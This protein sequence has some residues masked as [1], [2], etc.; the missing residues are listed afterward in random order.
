[1]V[2]IELVTC[3]FEIKTE[4][5]KS[6][7]IKKFSRITLSAVGGSASAL[8]LLSLNLTCSNLVAPEDIQPGR[9]DYVWTVDTLD[10]GMNLMALRTI[11]GANPDDV[12]VA[13]YASP[14]RY[15]LW[16]WDGLKWRPD[17]I[18]SL[19]INGTP[20]GL[21]GFSKD[22]IWLNSTDGGYYHFDGI[23]W[24][25]RSVHRFQDYEFLGLNYLFG[26]S[27]NNIYSVGMAQKN[28]QGD[29]HVGIIMRFDGKEWRFIDIPKMKIIFP[30]IGYQYSSK[31][32]FVQGYKYYTSDNPEL[33][34]LFNGKDLIELHRGDGI[35]TTGNIKGEIYA[36][37]G[38]KIFKYRN[39][40]ILFKDFTDQ[41]YKGRIWGRSEKDFFTV[42]ADGIGHY[43]G[44][45]LIT[46]FKTTNMWPQNAVIYD[47]EVFFLCVDF[48][49]WTNAVIHGKLKE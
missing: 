37:L 2:Y 4:R 27:P 5:G 18:N 20:S 12:W 33:L 46:I 32:Y 40:L 9:R 39:G 28:P 30:T 29:D 1:L 48:N 19:K 44:E 31:E 36:C 38:T 21:W 7:W 15:Q 11:W 6:M 34:F 17:T 41:N 24:S 25:R 23:T 43:N 3:I 13:G 35:V 22:N 49:T 45:D 47:K 16:H 42:Q 8:A 10:I 14:G 26:T